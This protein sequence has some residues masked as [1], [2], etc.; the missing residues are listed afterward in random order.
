MDLKKRSGLSNVVSTLVVLVVAV[1]LAGLVTYFGVNTTTT[2]TSYE[3]LQFDSEHVWVN[4]TGCVAAARVQAVGG[5]DLL[6]DKI[7]VRTRD[8]PWSNVYYYRVPANTEISNDM[9]L[10]S[11]A[12]LTGA[13]VTLFGKTY[14]QATDDLP[15]TS[16]GEVLFYVKN[17]GYIGIDDIGTIVNINVFTNNAEYVIEINVESA[18]SN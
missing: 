15:L 2:R 4:G 17:P 18:T 7:T 6:I 12:L 16:G 10:T 1:L 9:N 3:S 8:C 11:S 5:K 14:I 13:S